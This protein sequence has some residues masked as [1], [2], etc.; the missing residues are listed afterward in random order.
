MLRNELTLQGAT[1]LFQHQQSESGN[2][3][4]HLKE[5]MS[6]QVTKYKDMQQS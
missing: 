5:P 4:K 6:S 2:L 3:G 1:N